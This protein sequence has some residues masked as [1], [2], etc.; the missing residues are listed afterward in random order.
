MQKTFELGT[1]DYKFPNI[2]DHLRLL[3]KRSKEVAENDEAFNIAGA[4]DMIKPY[5]TNVDCKLGETA[6]D[7]VEALMELDQAFPVLVEIAGAFLTRF[8]DSD[9]KKS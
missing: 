8:A 4:L 3:S 6:I 5:I 7:T 9:R 2:P 1:V